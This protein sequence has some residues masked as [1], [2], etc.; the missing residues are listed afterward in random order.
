MKMVL[1]LIDLFQLQ[2]TVTDVNRCKF[3]K[4]SSFIAVPLPTACAPNTGFFIFGH[5][6]LLKNNKLKG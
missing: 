5:K 3:T 4:K 6:T 1:T 2:I